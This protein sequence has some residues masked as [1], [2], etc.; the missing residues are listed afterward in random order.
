MA[1]IT[2]IPVIHSST[3]SFIHSSL[4]IHLRKNKTTHSSRAD[5]SWAHI[6]GSAIPYRIIP[7]HCISSMYGFYICRANEADVIIW[8]IHGGA[9]IPLQPVSLPTPKQGFRAEATKRGAPGQKNYSVLTIHPCFF[10]FHSHL[11]C[12]ILLTAAKV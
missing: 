9:A 8:P 5:S 1:I 12:F 11:S 6:C 4:S 2:V 3:H 10:T 7:I